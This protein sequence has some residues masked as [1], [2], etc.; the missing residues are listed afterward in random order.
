M[1]G[2]QADTRDS[3]IV[4]VAYS[5]CGKGPHEGTTVLPT[6]AT[7]HLMSGNRTSP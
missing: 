2:E 1:N 3:F 4:I 5:K 6:G 7:G